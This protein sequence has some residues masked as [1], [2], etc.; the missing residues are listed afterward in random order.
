[1]IKISKMVVK[2][3]QTSRIKLK[4]EGFQDTMMAALLIIYYKEKKIIKI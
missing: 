1:M 3:K 4:Q 2:Y